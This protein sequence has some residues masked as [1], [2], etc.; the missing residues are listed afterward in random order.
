MFACILYTKT[1]TANIFSALILIVCAVA[2]DCS[3]EMATA[4]VQALCR[5]AEIRL[6][7]RHERG[8]AARTCE[9]DYT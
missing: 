1:T 6:H 9:E 2:F 5:E 7:R 8:H 3:S 4:A